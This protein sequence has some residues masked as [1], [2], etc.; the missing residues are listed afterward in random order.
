VHALQFRLWLFFLIVIYSSPAACPLHFSIIK[1]FS[2]QCPSTGRIW[3]NPLICGVLLLRSC[4]DTAARES[5][6]ARA[7]VLA[8]LE[9]GR[10][11]LVSVPTQVRVRHSIPGRFSLLRS[12]SSLQ[13]SV[14]RGEASLV[15][16]PFAL[17]F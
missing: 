17:R 1:S 8:T 14:Q 12:R 3:F 9:P 5:L 2:A 16:A 13:F 4:E 7:R 11:L 15:W 10:M 6:S